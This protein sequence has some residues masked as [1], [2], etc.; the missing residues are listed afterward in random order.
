M[1]AIRANVQIPP[2]FYDDVQQRM[3][4]KIAD[5]CRFSED[6]RRDRTQTQ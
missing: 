3:A 6:D 2:Q 1:Y 4:G 5:Y